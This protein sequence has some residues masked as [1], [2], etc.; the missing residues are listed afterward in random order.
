MSRHRLHEVLLP[1]DRWSARAVS[2]IDITHGID[3]GHGE[4]VIFHPGWAKSPERHAEL[5]IK[6]ANS[7][8]LPI[9]VDTRYAYADRQHIRGN[10][11]TQPMIVGKSNPYFKE[12][13][14]TGNRWQYRRPT[15]LLEICRR[16][17]IKE[18]SYVGH[19]D[20]GRVSALAAAASRES[21][22][23][24]IVV[25]GGGMGNSSKGVQRIAKSNI[26]RAKELLANDTNIA[27]NT[28]SALGSVAYTLT[29][30]RRFL[31]EKRVLQAADT[32]EVIG[33]VRDTIDVTVLHAMDD[34]LISFEDCRRISAA[35]PEVNFVP[36]PGG[37]SNIYES[38]VQDLIVAALQK[39]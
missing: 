4:V 36:T 5:L 25:N 13:G 30:P 26:N 7:D 17:G 32:W 24:L 28:A 2:P 10:L 14:I 23:K 31:A 9:G 38:S 20:G 34:E 8:F 35:H 19:S 16:L 12:A 33:K 6:L 3:D 15:V 22:R 39:S 27:E 21:T 29:H 37:H 1:T 18:R 11:L